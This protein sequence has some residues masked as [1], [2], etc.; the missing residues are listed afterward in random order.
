MQRS[1][2]RILTTHVGSLP[3]PDD[4]DAMIR[5]KAGGRGGRRGRLRRAGQERRRRDRAAPGRGRHRHRR[6]RRDG[7]GRLHPLRQRAPR[8]H[9]AEPSG[10]SRQLLERCRASTR[11]S[12]NS[13]PGPVADAGRRRA[14]PAAPAGCAP[15]RSPTRATPRSQRD[16]ANLKAALAGRA[17]TRKRSCRRCRPPTSPTGTAT[18]IYKSEEEY[19]YALADALREEYQAIID[20]GLI[21]QVDDPLLASYYVMHPEASIE[22]CRDW[23]ATRVDA[24]NHAL[25]GLPAGPHPL[26]HLL[27]HQY[28]PA[29][30]RHGAEEHRRH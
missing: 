7:P 4:L 6:R 3:R 22:D 13:T 16:I 17:L 11:R 14:A 23:A 19:L 27:Q 18:S 30:P 21:L 28:R 12:R 24:L 15:A 1:T 10:E 9:R 8:R 29:R 2:D 25:R 20:A 26:P 5:K